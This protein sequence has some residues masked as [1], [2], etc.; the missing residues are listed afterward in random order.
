[1]K[2]FLV[3]I[4]VGIVLTLA[5]IYGYFEW[6]YVTP[7]GDIKGQKAVFEGKDVR[8]KGIAGKSATI[9]SKGGYLLTDET[10]TIVVLTESGAPDENE[11]VTV[12]GEVDLILGVPVIRP[13]T[14]D[15][16][17]PEGEE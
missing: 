1:M 9:G 12:Y 2:K 4:F 10:G 15:D 5:G 3:G 11:R 7:I 13:P 14:P 6:V 8:L 17:G 16:S